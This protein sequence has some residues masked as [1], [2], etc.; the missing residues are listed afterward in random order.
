MCV[1][2]CGVISP[3]S[4]ACRAGVRHHHRG[5]RG[6]GLASLC[7]EVYAKVRRGPWALRSP[8]GVFVGF[9]CLFVCLL[10]PGACEKPVSWSGGLGG[11]AVGETVSWVSALPS[12]MLVLFTP[13]VFPQQV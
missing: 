8:R 6:E 1:C 13:G 11:E 2:R 10:R 9:F 7:C 3:V 12:D 4:T 5:W